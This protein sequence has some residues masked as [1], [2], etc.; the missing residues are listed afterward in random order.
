MYEGVSK[1][2]NQDDLD[3]CFFLCHF[4]TSIALKCIY[5]TARKLICV[6]FTLDRDGLQWLS[7]MTLSYVSGHCKQQQ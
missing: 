6:R 7:I 2:S 1:F 5:K 4:Y 3:C